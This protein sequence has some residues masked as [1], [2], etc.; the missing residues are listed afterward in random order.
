MHLIESG[1]KDTTHKAGKNYPETVM[2]E[3]LLFICFPGCSGFASVLLLHRRDYSM[4]G[5][6]GR[7]IR[8]TSMKGTEGHSKREV[9][10]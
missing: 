5:I 8:P 1:Q 10:D 9:I 6:G 4:R 7:E 3:D 2:R